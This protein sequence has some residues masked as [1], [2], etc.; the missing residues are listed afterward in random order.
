M[1]TTARQLT[2]TPAIPLHTS[3]KT[4]LWKTRPDV[5]TRLDASTPSLPVL[6][7]VLTKVASTVSL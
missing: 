5:G 7:K 1:V 4:F 6:A 2:Y 3:D